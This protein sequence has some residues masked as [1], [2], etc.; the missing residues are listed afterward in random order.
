[1]LLKSKMKSCILGVVPF[2]ISKYFK[3]HDMLENHEMKSSLASSLRTDL[4]WTSRSSQL[5]SQGMHRKIS[6]TPYDALWHHACVGDGTN[7]SHLR[8]R[9][10]YLCQPFRCSLRTVVMPLIESQCPALS[11]MPRHYGHD[12][13]TVHADHAVSRTWPVTGRQGGRKGTWSGRVRP[14]RSHSVIIPL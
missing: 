14:Y 8:Q 4:T 5:P 10:P 11:W 6:L 13:G 9:S 3:W 1:M 7:T 12:C 2:A